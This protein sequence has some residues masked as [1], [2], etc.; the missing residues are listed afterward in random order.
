[1]TDTNAPDGVRELPKL[2]YV[3]VPR[4]P[5]I[6]RAIEALGG[7]IKLKTRVQGRT[8]SDIPAEE[9]AGMLYALTELM[10]YGIDPEHQDQKMGAVVQGYAQAMG[11][12]Y[13]SAREDRDALYMAGLG[14]KANLAA[15]LLKA[16]AEAAYV[17]QSRLGKAGTTMVAS[18]LADAAGSLALKVAAIGMP[19]KTYAEYA[20]E[21]RDL[22]DHLDKFHESESRPGGAL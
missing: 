19:T 21:L 10:V 7:T 15:M 12:G 8:A 14:L 5:A 16:G 20:A 1:M 18:R 6:R 2:P 9:L 4:A 22:A 11:G 13:E 3:P 17:G